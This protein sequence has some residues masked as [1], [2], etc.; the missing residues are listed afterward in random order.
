MKVA[1]QL[2]RE[3]RACRACKLGEGLV[4]YAA[5]HK[6]PVLVPDVSKD[7]RY[8]KVVDDVRSELVI[9]LLLQ[10]SL[11]RR[12]RSREPRARRVHASAT[13]RS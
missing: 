6:E 12:V 7:P 11:H 4:G 8:I 2:R 10:G 5:L 9:P 3:G 1:V 13:S